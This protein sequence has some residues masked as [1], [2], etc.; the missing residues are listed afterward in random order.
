M[1]KQYCEIC[2]FFKEDA[3]QR[4]DPRLEKKGI[5]R[6]IILCEACYTGLQLRKTT[7]REWMHERVCI[8][9]VLR[10]PERRLEDTLHILIT[11]VESAELTHVQ[12]ESKRS[13]GYVW[14]NL[15]SYDYVQRERS[16]VGWQPIKLFIDV[17]NHYRPLFTFVKLDETHTRI[18]TAQKF[19]L[20]NGKGYIQ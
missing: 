6:L 19:L 20:Y 18:L 15:T 10:G 4:K 14:G 3:I 9:Y 7:M 2:S 13:E 8:P 5:L 12:F 16:L 17:V 1:A 11:M